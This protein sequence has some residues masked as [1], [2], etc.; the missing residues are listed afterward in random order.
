MKTIFLKILFVGALCL[1][2]GAV[3]ILTGIFA[4]SQITNERG[5]CEPAIQISGLFPKH[6]SRLLDY[7]Y[8]SNSTQCRLEGIGS[9]CIYSTGIYRRIQDDNP[10]QYRRLL[11]THKT[12]IPG[13]FYNPDD[14]N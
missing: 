3:P 2:G 13:G 14:N 7:L 12:Q 8:Y 5:Y 6:N 9:N 4:A 11:T 10:R 1:V